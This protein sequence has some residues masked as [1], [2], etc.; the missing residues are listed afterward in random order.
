MQVACPRCGTENAIDESEQ[1]ADGRVRTRCTQCDAKLLIK[2][3][4]PDLKVADDIPAT[5]DSGE[6][7]VGLASERLAPLSEI[8]IDLGD[9]GE[10]ERDSWHVLVIHELEWSKVGDLRR[11]LLGLPRFKRNPNKMQD[12]TSEFPFVIPD[13]A[14]DGLKKLTDLLEGADARWETG[15]RHALLNARGELRPPEPEPVAE[16]VAEDEVFAA[17]DDDDADEGLFV[18][19]GDEDGDGMLATGEHPRAE[20]HDGAEASGDG[21][22]PEGAAEARDD[23][24]RTAGSQSGADDDALALGDDE[25][26]ALGDDEESFAFGDDGEA[27]AQDADGGSE[28]AEE[29]G[30]LLIAGDD[31]SLDGPQDHVAAPPEPQPPAPEDPESTQDTFVVTDDDDDG[32]DA[33]A[34]ALFGPAIT[35]EKLPAIGRGEP[36]APSDRESIGP[37]TRLPP[38]PATAAAAA[39][40]AVALNTLTVPVG[41]VEVLG[42]VCAVVVVSAADLTATPES[43]VTR[44]MFQVRSELRRATRERGGDAV[45][46]LHTSP[47]AVGGGPTAGWMVLAEGTAVRTV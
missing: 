20:A 32:S 40:S 12:V 3:N 13:L 43:A 9:E 31:D 28:P 17:G 36:P 5:Q 37:S 10:R 25:P 1:A 33:A 15:S 38:R 22:E 23:S 24:E 14:A 47:S 6:N 26:L 16:V 19:G 45:W 29:D 27:F 11:A 7:D 39:E 2:V 35:R 21:T 44:A 30:D 46:G 4:R 34:E 42:Y 18:A 8:E 41:S